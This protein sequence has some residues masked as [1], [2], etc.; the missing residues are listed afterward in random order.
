MAPHLS[1][2]SSDVCEAPSIPQSQQQNVKSRKVKQKKNSKNSPAIKMC[3]TKIDNNDRDIKYYGISQSLVNDTHCYETERVPPL[4]LLT[5][6]ILIAKAVESLT[7]SSKNPS[8]QL[9]K[10]RNKKKQCVL[11]ENIINSKS[12]SVEHKDYLNNPV[13]SILCASGNSEHPTR[14]ISNVCTP[15]RCGACG[16][17]FLTVESL[18]QHLLKHIYEGMYAAQWLTQA[19]T[20]VSQHQEQTTQPIPLVSQHQEQTDAMTH[21]SQ[22]QDQTLTMTP[23]HDMG[24]IIQQEQYASLLQQPRMVSIPQKQEQYASLILQQASTQPLQL[25]ETAPT[26]YTQAPLCT[27]TSHSHT[28]CAQ[29]AAFTHEKN[30]L[31]NCKNTVKNNSD[32]ET[33]QTALISPLIQ[34]DRN[35]H[36]LPSTRKQANHSVKSQC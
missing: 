17:E 19:M 32:V 10:R 24:S 27:P 33:E 1:I 6:D 11:E 22:Y 3:N 20:L 9:Q 8:R 12:K 30:S 2:P 21:G 16:L 7:I 26:I 15:Q 36:E 28:V 4:P 5:E 31:E 18:S 23:Q 34:E 14:Q 29:D 25:Q 35:S 13:N